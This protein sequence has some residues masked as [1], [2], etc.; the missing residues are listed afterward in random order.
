MA[1][2]YIL[3]IDLGT[4]GPKVAL[5]ST[6]GELLASEFEEV[7]LLLFED[8]GAEQ[9]PDEWWSAVDKATKRLLNRRL[10]PA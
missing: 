5:F 10:I 8:G 4:S 9:V 6:H 3:A 2:K 7:R 1:D